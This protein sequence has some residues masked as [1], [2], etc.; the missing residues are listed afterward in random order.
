M[1][2][3]YKL[4]A[5]AACALSTYTAA[6]GAPAGTL[7]LNV[8]EI[9]LSQTPNLK[10]ERAARFEA[11]QRYV[12]VLD[13]P[14]T[15]ARAAELRR[16]GVQLHD[17]LPHN[18]HLADLGGA[19]AAGLLDVEFVAGILRFESAWKLD[20]ALG[21]R[22]YATPQRQA[23]ARQGLLAATLTL[24]SGRPAA[25]VVEALRRLPDATIHWIASI[26]GQETISVTLRRADAA[27]LADLADVQYVEE[28]PEITLRN[29][30]TRWIVQT[31]VL[32]FTPLYVHGVTGIGQIVG[33]M[34]GRVNR[35][36]CSFRDPVD[37]TP[38]PG[39]RKIQAYNTSFGYDLHGTHV[40][41]TAIGQDADG[42]TN[43]TRGIAYDGRLVFSNVPS[44]TDTAM[45]SALS[46][47]HSQGARVHSNSWG[48]DGTTNYNSLCRGIDRFSHDYE[49]SLVIFAVTNTNTLKNPENAKNCLAVGASNDA[50]TQSS[51]C[52]FTSGRGPTSDGRRKPEIYAPG[53][54]TFSSSG[55][56]Q[57]CST[58][59]L[60][61]TSM[62]A[63]A[64]AGVSLLVRQYYLDGYYPSGT[65]TP[66]DSFV[67]SG[68]LLKATLLN[69]AVDM[70]GHSGYPS[71]EGWGRVLI[72]NVLY[73]PGDARKLIVADDLRNASGR[74]TNEQ[75]EYSFTVLGST[76]QLRL[77]L[78]W[79]DPPASASTGSALALIND[80]DLEV[81]APDSSLYL[82]N[83]FSGGSSV[84]GGA[85]D[86]RNNVEQVHVNSPA[87]G[88]WMARVR[89]AAVNTGLQ[90]YALV[91]S[92]DVTTAA[93]APTLVSI[94]PNTGVADTVVPISDISGTYFQTSGT[95]SVRLKKAGR[96]DI[97]A[98]GVSVVDADTIVCQF[99][100]SGAVIG[101][102]DVVVTNPDGQS[103]DLPAGFTVTVTCLR[104]DVNGDTLVDG[105]D[106]A[107]FVEIL[108]G[109]GDGGTAVERCGGDLE[110][111]PNGL[112]DENDVPAFADCLLAEGCP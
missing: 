71:K 35:D 111:V 41:G 82:G 66:A 104:G 83:V 28:S 108:V 23:L 9:D 52:P 30:S 4:L 54:N 80:L 20:P 92:G 90:G 87:A 47:A 98:D 102:Y 59:G 31:N 101:A 105:G 37:N 26:G 81:V 84:T 56:G 42:S 73:F 40:A 109:G 14:M 103:A 27:G 39:H 51:A 44:Y 99:D 97:V 100:L 60:T 68:A 62:A 46:L 74:S 49:E 69:S 95:T 48:D 93:P 32:N 106:I 70:T 55:S 77:T 18:A 112:I 63:P 50:P 19:N 13:G 43:D 61:G 6:I 3:R 8:G 88:P 86:D 21:T 94:S 24:F 22:V 72:D 45:Y 110:A 58:T 36:H 57:V 75:A 2:I 34:D 15:Q 38:G 91:I 67:P 7:L 79:T 10:T 96:P 25:P 107:R 78:V 12:L 17:Y 16:V 85:K 89:A 64:I 1:L 5:T 29:S 65:P 33:I 53:C 76:E 11:G